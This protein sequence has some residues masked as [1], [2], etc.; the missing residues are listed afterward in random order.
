MSTKGKRESELA[1]LDKLINE[2]TVDAYGDDEKL[3][4]FGQAF[5]DDAILPADGFIIGE[6][7]SVVEID[8]DGND[9]LA[10]SV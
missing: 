3:W 2:I 9:A 7:V 5:E 1:A 6:P 4:A 8:Y 10:Q